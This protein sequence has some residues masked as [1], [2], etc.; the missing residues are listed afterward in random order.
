M[1]IIEHTFEEYLQIVRKFHGNE[2]P[3]VVIGGF[4]VD[5]AIRNLPDAIL[6]DA[7]CETRS[8]LPDAIQI[9]TPCTVGN[10]WLKVIPLGRFALTLYD[11][12]TYEGVRVFLDAEKLD[13][14]PEIRAWLFKLKS[15][16]EQGRA[17]ILREIG[18]AGPSIFTI[19]Q[20]NVRPEVAKKLHKG[21]IAVCLQ[22]GEAYPINDGTLCLSCQGNSPYASEEW[23]GDGTCERR[24]RQQVIGR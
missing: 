7:I 13:A 5:L 20:V 23:S 10:G 14:W 22:C 12:R 19:Q 2:A 21:R 1:N 24:L 6:Y 9:L 17:G 18:E 4:M 15:K 11:K 16:K 3:G 8:C